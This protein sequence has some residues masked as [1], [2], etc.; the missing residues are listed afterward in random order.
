MTQIPERSRRGTGTEEEPRITGFPAARGL[1]EPPRDIAV[2]DAG[3]E[4]L[5]G[6]AV[7][8]RMT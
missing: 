2:Q 8:D 5:I 6:Q 7:F 1:H 3:H 4:C